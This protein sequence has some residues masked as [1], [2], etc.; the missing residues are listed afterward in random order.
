MWYKR[1][2]GSCSLCKC[3]VL[4]TQSLGYKMVLQKLLIEFI[5]SFK[6]CKKQ[7]IFHVKRINHQKS[8]LLVNDVVMMF[9]SPIRSGIFFLVRSSK[10]GQWLIWGDFLRYRRNFRIFLQ[11]TSIMQE[12]QKNL[13][14]SNE[15]KIQA[16]NSLQ[17]QKIL[18]LYEKQQF[19]GNAPKVTMEF[20]GKQTRRS[21]FKAQRALVPKFLVRY[22]IT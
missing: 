12:M 13:S 21:N 18:A 10:R 3:T 11:R 16:R 14:P 20:R 5:H 15:C 17:L 2:V 7:D 22:V 9:L 19:L 8:F 4:E 6:S 1:F